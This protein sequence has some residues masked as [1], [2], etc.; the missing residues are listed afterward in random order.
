[1][2]FFKYHALG[3]DYIVMEQAALPKTLN[4]EEVV[5][6]CH[7]NF[8]VGSDGILMFEGQIKSGSGA[9]AF[10]VTIFNPDGSQ[11]EN[12]GNGM[13]IFSRFLFDA[14]HVR[15][16]HFNI[17]VGGQRA[18]S[19][20][21]FEGAHEVEVEMGKASFLS[22][23][24]PVLGPDREVIGEKLELLGETLVVNCVSVGNP[25]CVVF[26]RHD[27][28]DDALRFGS[29]IENHER[30]P[31]RINVQFARVVDRKRIEAEIWERGAGYT[32]ASGSSASAIASAARKLG[33]VGSGV[34]VHM[35]GGNLFVEVSDS[36]QIRIRGPVTRVGEGRI[37]P[38]I[39]AN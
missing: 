7:R 32:L 13:R 10:A 36:F 3:N 25:H 27:L 38:E 35:P 11:A 24:I 20:R 2:E 30:F 23:E 19:A 21:V 1:M 17:L 34:T 29:L 28:K 6:I 4:T 39:F 31:K 18:I 8:G 16:D 22:S 5:R 26:G 14:G 12:S 15:N 37:C 9:G 33:L